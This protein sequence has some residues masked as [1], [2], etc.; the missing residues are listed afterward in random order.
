M[1]GDFENKTRRSALDLESVENGRQALVELH[2]HDGTDD[3]HDAALSARCARFRLCSRITT[4]KSH[5]FLNTSTP[6]HTHKDTIFWLILST[7]LYKNTKFKH[8]KH[9]NNPA[10]I[11]FISR[12]YLLLVVFSTK[13]LE[14]LEM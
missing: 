3:R 12:N 10:R 13:V 1:L 6:T 9:I 8:L 11:I 14:M 4:F 2:V 5:I 7:F